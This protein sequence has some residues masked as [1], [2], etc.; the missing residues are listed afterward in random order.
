VVIFGIVTWLSA[1]DVAYPYAS[2][3]DGVISGDPPASLRDVYQE[4][5]F[6]AYLEDTFVPNVFVTTDYN[7]S[8]LDPSR[9]GYVLDVDKIIGS[10]RL[11]QKRVKDDRTLC[12]IPPVYASLIDTCYPRIRSE[13]DVSAEVYG[14]EDR[15]TSTATGFFADF[16]GQRFVQDLPNDASVDD[17]IATLRSLRKDSWIDAQTREVRVIFTVY[18]PAADLFCNVQLFFHFA[19]TGGIRVEASFR[20]ISML[21]QWLLLTPTRTF[22]PPELRHQLL[23]ALELSFLLM[24]LAMVVAEVRQLARLGW[25]AYISSVWNVI[26]LF[27]LSLFIIFFFFRFFFV[28]LTSLLDFRPSPSTYSEFRYMAGLV[29]QSQNLTAFNC[30]LTYIKMFKY[31]QFSTRLS[32]LTHTLTEASED[33]AGFIFMFLLVFMA[34]AFSFHM[35]FGMDVSSFQDFTN[36]FFTLFLIILGDFNFEQLR[37]AN[38]LLGPLL[39]ISYI[40]I[41]YLILFNMF[42]AI[43]GEAYVRVKEKTSAFEDPF[44]RNIRAGL[45]SRKQRRLRKLEKAIGD[46]AGEGDRVV[47][48]RDIREIEV[49]LRE[50]LGDAEADAIMLKIAQEDELG[51]SIPQDELATLMSRIVESR[52]KLEREMRQQQAV[53]LTRQLPEEIE[54]KDP[55]FALRVSAAKAARDKIEQIELNQKNLFDSIHSSQKAVMLKISSLTDTME[56]IGSKLATLKAVQRR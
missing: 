14:P 30:V 4:S 45:S 40:V 24:V 15:F 50:I 46:A 31:L 16:G 18:N 27:N 25:F 32:Q 22:F 7:D 55:A 36:S 17:V 12:P 54:A 3:I 41:V 28:A 51:G 35:A 21:R 20:T 39:F 33:L 49:E 9:L 1:I 42:L 6:W 29:Y 37:L 13:L 47:T 44:I 48:A 53:D 34:Y 23:F 43:I 19:H 2:K 10:V 26:D 56:M 5:Q 52:E 38:D 11:E 8:P